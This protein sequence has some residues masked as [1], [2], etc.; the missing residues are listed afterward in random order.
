MGF[1]E[2]FM[3]KA[4]ISKHTPDGLKYFILNE[5]IYIRGFEH[6][7]TFQEIPSQ[8]ENMP[9]VSIE[10]MQE[11]ALQGEIILP[12]T[13]RRIA[14]M[15]FEFQKYVTKFIIPSSVSLIGEHAFA[16][17]DLL[18]EIIF[19]DTLEMLPMGGGIEE[20]PNLK[21]IHL[22]AGLKEIPE[23]FAVGCTSLESIFIPDSVVKIGKNA[24]EGCTNLK[25][26][27]LPE[28]LK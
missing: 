5:E 25:S 27:R 22:P 6:H 9:V 13:L 2:Q 4:G 10:N 16:F 3:M 26:I 24:F 15:C 7:A 23:Y 11:S 18:E 8:I 17:C 19:P 12:D 1:K 28:H 21:Q 20:C 14:D